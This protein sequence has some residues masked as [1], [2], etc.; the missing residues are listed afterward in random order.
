MWFRNAVIY[1]LTRNFSLNLDTIE[2]SLRD[3]SFPTGTLEVVKRSG[4]VNPALHDVGQSTGESAPLFHRCGHYTA[5][6]IKHEKKKLPAKVVKAELRKTIAE[7]EN[8]ESRKVRGKE[9]RTIKEELLVRLTKRAFTEESETHLMFIKNQYLVVD[10]N[11]HTQAESAIAFLRKAIGSL[12]CVPLVSEKHVETELS[13]WVVDGEPA[14]F[15]LDGT[16]TLSSI[17]A[18]EPVTIKYKNEDKSSEQVISYLKNSMVVSE[19]QF[20][21]QNQ[22]TCRLNDAFALKNCRFSD[23]LKDQNSDI[24]RED[25]LARF[26]ADFLL[27]SDTLSNLIEDIRS[28]FSTKPDA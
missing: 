17:C 10:A 21:Y 12:P 26:D 28:A 18:G 7:I 14:G 3:F 22:L 25:Q 19:A 2:K 16:M 24:P 23:E 27:M 5:I 15:C 20:D 11:S 13:R 9:K 8:R 4:F 6:T 1:T